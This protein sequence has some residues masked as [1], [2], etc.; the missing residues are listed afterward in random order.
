MR[1]PVRVGYQYQPGRITYWSWRTFRTVREARRWA[2]RLNR[3]SR[4]LPG[5]WV[6]RV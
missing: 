1:Q 3:N 6:V 5:T 2:A 4:I